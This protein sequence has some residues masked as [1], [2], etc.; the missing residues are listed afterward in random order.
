MVKQSVISVSL[1]ICWPLSR[2]SWG[3]GRQCSTASWT[4]GTA[5]SA[6]PPSPPPSLYSASWEEAAAWG[7]GPGCS[8][9]R[10]GKVS[11]YGEIDLKCIHR[12][13]RPQSEGG[14]CLPHRSLSAAGYPSVCLRLP[15]CRWWRSNQLERRAHSWL[16]C[17]DQRGRVNLW[18]THRSS[19]RRCPS[20]PSRCHRVLSHSVHASWR[21]SVQTNVAMSGQVRLQISQ[22]VS[23]VSWLFLLTWMLPS[24]ARTSATG[25]DWTNCIKPGI[26]TQLVWLLQQEG[27]HNSWVTDLRLFNN[28][29]VFNGTITYWWVVAASYR[30]WCWWP[31]LC[32]VS[33]SGPNS[34]FSIAIHKTKTK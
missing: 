9:S 29:C 8:Q 33:T 22:N 25:T 23:Q 1:R 11:L 2:T 18:Q 3:A 26:M 30:A 16:D 15:G 17:R 19:S 14:A 7:P 20:P 34:L 4:P 12:F 6:C 21:S 28:I 5:R 32:K 13:N 31:I 10:C 24:V 27:V